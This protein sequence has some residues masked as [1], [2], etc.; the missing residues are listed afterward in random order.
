[1]GET[2]WLN[3]AVHTFGTDMSTFGHLGAAHYT[4]ICHLS[5]H[6]F[7]LYPMP[8]TTSRTPDIAMASNIKFYCIQ[9][10]PK[11]QRPNVLAFSAME[12]GCVFVVFSN[13]I[14][15]FALLFHLRAASSSVYSDCVR[16]PHFQHF[17][18]K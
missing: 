2:I 3:G 17:T 14:H 6:L 15:V 13:P 8:G 1:L 9:P 4:L 5:Y 7:C 10:L 12:S 16:A 18:K 11:S